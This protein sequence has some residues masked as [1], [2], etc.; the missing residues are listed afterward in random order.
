MIS[1]NNGLLALAKFLTRNKR[2]ARLTRMNAQPVVLLM[3][4]GVVGPSG[5]HVMNA[6]FK[7]APDSV[8]DLSHKTEVPRV[9]NLITSNNSV[10]LITVKMDG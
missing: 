8:I 6:V 3:A 2:E 4:D 7:V 1:S 9:M 5:R 10:Q